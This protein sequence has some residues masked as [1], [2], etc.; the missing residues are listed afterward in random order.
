MDGRL[1]HI[2]TLFRTA[3]MMEGLICPFLSILKI[4]KVFPGWEWVYELFEMYLYVWVFYNICVCVLWVCLIFF[5]LNVPLSLDEN[6]TQFHFSSSDSCSLKHFT[7]KL[8]YY[9]L[10]ICEYSHHFHSTGVERQ[11][12]W[13]TLWISQ[14]YQ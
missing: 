2:Y 5:S 9:S 3:F 7:Y 13:E 4:C 12:Y 8:N 1:E 11:K 6:N 14:N 10:S